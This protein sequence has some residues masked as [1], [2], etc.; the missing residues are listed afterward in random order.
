VAVP[1]GDELAQV[2]ASTA[3]EDGAEALQHVVDP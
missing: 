1:P 2:P 3:I